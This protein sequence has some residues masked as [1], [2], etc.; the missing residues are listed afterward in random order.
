MFEAIRLATNA[1]EICGLCE[2]DYWA[3]LRQS[4]SLIRQ[5]DHHRSV[6]SIPHPEVHPQVNFEILKPTIADLFRESR[7]KRIRLRGWQTKARPR[8]STSPRP[9]SPITKNSRGTQ[10]SKRPQIRMI[11]QQHRSGLSTLNDINRRPKNRRKLPQA[12]S[13]N[14]RRSNRRTPMRSN[15][16]GTNNDNSYSWLRKSRGIPSGHSQE[17]NQVLVVLVL[18]QLHRSSSS[19]NMAIGSGWAVVHMRQQGFLSQGPVAKVQH[20]QKKRRNTRRHFRR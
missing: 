12:P 3:N 15:F 1:S 8:A 17:K 9:P 13:L 18:G 16:E 10:T 4:S 14:D 5:S 20:R 7:F 2:Y 19:N 11:K 6:S